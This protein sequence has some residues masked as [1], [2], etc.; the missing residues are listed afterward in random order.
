MSNIPNIS[1][2]AW[3]QA[4][5]S[6][7][8][9]MVDLDWPLDNERVPRLHWL[10]TGLTLSSAN[11]SPDGNNTAVVNIPDPPVVQYMQPA[12]PVG[13]IAHSYNFYLFATLP[14][15]VLPSQYTGLGDGD[16][17]DEN[18]A[19]IAAESRVPFDVE[20]FLLD[21]GVDD[22]DVLA[23]NHVRVRNLTGT[24]PNKTFPPARQATGTLE[25]V[26]PEQ[27]AAP[28]QS[29]SS[30]RSSALRE[31]ETSMWLWAALFVLE[32]LMQAVV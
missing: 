30:G 11:P 18:G 26:V 7:F 2:P 32:G 24:D 31:L 27:S 13:D 3:S 12:P 21:C 1:T 25:D 17:F 10:V 19:L 28:S 16:S 6:A 14:D 5:P 8:L 9:L 4:N 23:R 29:S 22:S 15:F 20:Q